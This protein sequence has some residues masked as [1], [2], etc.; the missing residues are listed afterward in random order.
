MSERSAAPRGGSGSDVRR[1]AVLDSAIG[2]FARFGYR[3]TSM[4]DVAADARISRPGLYFL[5]ASKVELFRAAIER[6]IEQ[7]LSAVEQALAADSPLEDRVLQA[8]DCW[9]GRYIGPMRDAQALVQ[10]NPDLLGPVASASPDR[11][12]RMVLAAVA[13]ERDPRAVTQ[14][15]VSVSIGLKHQVSDRQDYLARMRT[16]LGLVLCTARPAA[17]SR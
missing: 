4:E 5:F 13:D 15:L 17:P 3:K 10:D 6:A 8:F 7:D 12:H 9:A 2:T 14:T 11:F 16:A 1:E